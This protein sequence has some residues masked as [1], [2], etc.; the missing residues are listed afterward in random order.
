M[1]L[2]RY[3]F[4]IY[5]I[6]RSG[7]LKFR[8]LLQILNFKICALRGSCSFFYGCGKAAICTDAIKAFSVWRG[9]LKVV[10][11]RYKQRV[12]QLAFAARRF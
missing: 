11:G 8:Y 2:R 4:K 5:R 12:L 3:N 9:A 7:I 10:F 1:G 6:Y